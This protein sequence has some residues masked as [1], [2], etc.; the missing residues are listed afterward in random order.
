MKSTHLSSTLEETLACPR[1]L[2]SLAEM[3]SMPAGN[4]GTRQPFKRVKP[5]QCAVVFKRGVK[6]LNVYNHFCSY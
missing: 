2:G 3:K 1:V 6:R 5:V 4:L